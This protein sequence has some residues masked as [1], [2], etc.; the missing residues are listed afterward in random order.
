MRNVG[1]VMVAEAR[2]HRSRRV[3]QGCQAGARPLERRDAGL[4]HSRRREGT[5]RSCRRYRAETR[6]PR[7]KDRASRGQGRDAAA[8]TRGRASPPG[9]VAIAAHLA[10]A[11]STGRERVDYRGHS[12]RA[13]AGLPPGAQLQGAWPPGC[14]IV[15]A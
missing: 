8:G 7:T 5:W 14:A 6:P 1:A 2:A 15:G 3:Y 12:R 9:R 10:G 13:R 4:G 11:A